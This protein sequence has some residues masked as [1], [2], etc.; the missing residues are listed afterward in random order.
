MASLP[1]MEPWVRWIVAI[2]AGVVAIVLAVRWEKRILRTLV[3]LAGDSVGRALAVLLGF[4]AA[5]TGVAVAFVVAGVAVWALG[6]GEVGVLV[7]TAVGVVVL[8]PFAVPL[9]PREG[10]VAAATSAGDLR[11]A[12]GSRAVA[13]TLGWGG[14]LLSFVTV[15]PVVLAAILLGFAGL[16]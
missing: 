15:M 9:L 5:W 13:R 12:G 2:G 6:G 10:F 1:H 4:Y 3:R 14:A 16:R 7:V 8:V 11:R